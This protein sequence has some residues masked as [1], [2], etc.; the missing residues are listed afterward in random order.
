MISSNEIDDEEEEEEETAKPLLI[1]KAMSDSLHKANKLEKMGVN[2][3]PTTDRS[4][5]FKRVLELIAP[6]REILKDFH[7]KSTQK[8]MIS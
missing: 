6:Y 2:M 8:S 7:K 5:K 4:F 3:D 1:V